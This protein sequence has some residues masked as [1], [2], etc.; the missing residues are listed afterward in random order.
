MLIEPKIRGFLCT[1]AHPD[2]CAAQVQEQITYVTKN[3]PIPKGPKKALLIGASTGYGLSTRVAA[4]FGSGAGTLAVSFERPSERGRTAS[5]GWYQTLAFETAAR[6]A[7][8]YAK[9][10]NGDAF[11]DALKTETLDILAKDLGAVDL[12]VYSLAAPRRT[13]PR[14]GA[15]HKSTLKPIGASYTNKTL[16]FNTGV[17]SNVT[18]DP[19]TPEEIEDTVAVMGGEDWEM[20]IDA[21]AARKLLAPGAMTMAYSY[22]GPKVTQPVYR[23]GT[24]GTAKNDLERTAHRLDTKMQTLG[25][26]AYISVNKAL[27]T[28]ASSA[29]PFMPLYISLLYKVMKQKGIHEGT[30]EQMDRLFRTRLYTGGPVATDEKNRIR[31]DDWELRED[32]QAEVDRLWTQVTT[33]NGPDIGDFQGYKNDFLRLFGFNIDGVDYTKDFPEDQI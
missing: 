10:L 32:V 3:G 13:H 8:L 11:T 31:M 22:I 24:I 30:L 25:G 9:S 16:D 33:E 2:G 19:A 21:L 20:W 4:A 12:V 28:Q 17:V 27:V 15:V 1:T 6:K 14:T 5:P 29:I 26:R 7:G 18:L 23:N